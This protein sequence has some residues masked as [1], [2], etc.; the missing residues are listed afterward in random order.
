MESL[1]D[2]RRD[3]RLVSA[4]TCSN[5]DRALRVECLLH[6]MPVQI[7]LLTISG[8][9]EASRRA[10]ETTFSLYDMSTGRGI[11]AVSAMPY[12]T[13]GMLEFKLKHRDDVLFERHAAQYVLL[14]HASCLASPHDST[15]PADNHLIQ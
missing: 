7:M 6:T 14:A 2:T 11:H 8:D 3:I 13:Y 1:Y 12:F 4:L 15:L 9:S 5:L 10:F